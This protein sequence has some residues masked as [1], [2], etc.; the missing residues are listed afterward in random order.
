MHLFTFQ[1]CSEV[2]QMAG[3]PSPTFAR[4]QPST[5]KV[6][7]SIIAI[8]KY[9]Q[10]RYFLMVVG[11]KTNWLETADALKKLSTRNNITVRGVVYFDEPYMSGGAIQNLILE[12][13]ENTHS[14]CCKSEIKMTICYK[15]EICA[16]IT[17]EL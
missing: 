8:L 5:S 1:K 10:W 3:K 12:T 15:N 11:R 14:K 17:R 16:T 4:T 2:T 7:E 6:S 13:Y 9:F